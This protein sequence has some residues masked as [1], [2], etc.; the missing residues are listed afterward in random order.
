MTKKVVKFIMTCLL[1]TGIFGGIACRHYGFSNAV[2]KGALAACTITGLVGSQYFA[3][4]ESRAKGNGS[5]AVRI[6]NAVSFAFI[7]IFVG[8]AII[9]RIARL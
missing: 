2:V 3:W 7:V 1:F 9:E 6:V 8:W 4:M 5:R